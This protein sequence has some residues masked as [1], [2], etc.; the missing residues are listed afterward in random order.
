MV[1]PFL[2]AGAN[3]TMAQDNASSERVIPDRA[4]E[5]WF[6]GLPEIRRD[7]LLRVLTTYS[8]T[9]FFF[10]DGDPRGA[11]YELFRE[12]EKELNQSIRKM[13]DRVVVVFVPLSFPQ[14]TDALTGGHGDVLAVPMTV[15]PERAEQVAFTKPLAAEVDEIVVLHKDIQGID[16]L[17]DLAGRELYIRKG[18]SYA[19]SLAAQGY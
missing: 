11:V 17:E 13:A 7:R 18:T 5:P 15:T 2:F 3:S 12:Y 4:T 8:K 6:G 10:D 16:G 14:L 9:K 1:E 19:A